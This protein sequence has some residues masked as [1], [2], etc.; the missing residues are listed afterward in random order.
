MNDLPK[1]LAETL[2][3][4]EAV[5]DPEFRTAMLIDY[6]DRFKEVPERISKRPFPKENQVPF[7]ESEAYVWLEELP[8]KRLKLHFAVENPSGISAKALAAV[9]DASLSGL[10]AEEIARVTP[11]IVYKLFGR[12]ISMGKG[13]GLTALVEMVRSRAQKIAET[14]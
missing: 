11:E 4:F 8:D 7:C 13:Q 14:R 6:A 9:L 2:A 1:K 3:N 5:D 10:P 12:Q